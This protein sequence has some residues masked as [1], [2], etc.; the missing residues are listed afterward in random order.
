MAPKRKADA[1]GNA[2]KKQKMQ[3]GKKAEAPAPRAKKLL[4]KD[5]GDF[6]PINRWWEKDL[7]QPGA[8]AEMWKS[9]EHHGI[10]F[11]PPYE[12]HGKVLLY[13]GKPVKL[14]VEAE[15]IATYWA[16]CI[17]TDYVEKK[18]FQDN[19]WKSWKPT[20]PADT[21][22]TDFKKCDFRNIRKHLDETREARLGR[23]KEE[24]EAE[25]LKKQKQ[26]EYYRYAMVDGLRET[27]GNIMAEPPQL[28]RGRGEHP[29]MGLLKKRI[30][31]EMVTINCG[32]D[33]PVPK[34]P[35]PGHAWND[36]F[37]DNKSTWLGF[38]MDTINGMG[39]YVMLNAASGFKGQNDL[40]KYEKAR[41]LKKIAPIIRKDYEKL[42]DSKNIRERQVGVASYI[43]DRLALRAG[44]EKDT[45]E[46]ADTV[47]CCSLRVEHMRFEGDNKITLDFLGKD[48]I[49]YVNTVAVEPGV[50]RCLEG[51]SSGKKPD[52]MI[53]DQIDTGDVNEYFKRFMPELSAKVFRTYNASI[54][55]Q[56]ELAKFDDRDDIDP[57]NPNELL[58]FYNDANREVAILCNHQR[59]V[60]KSHDDTIAKMQGQLDDQ[61][62]L[63]AALEKHLKFFKGKNALAT[64]KGVEINGFK[65]P[66]SKDATTK[67]LG[68]VQ[69]RIVEQDRKIRMKDDNKTV[70]LGTS[71][72]NYMDPR[73]SVA[74]CKKRELQIEKI[75][76][77]S[78]RIKFPWAMH[79]PSTYEF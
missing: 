79:F 13:D 74:F 64:K 78:T 29:K 55:L 35:I 71:K 63:E 33:A 37:H 73:I 56:E 8:D 9:L 10:F 4:Q 7:E 23:S 32:E 43:I 1:G 75:F 30:V 12:P 66:T 14:D 16:S 69:N 48:S 28:F 6:E 68:E 26:E 57:Y 49:Q 21:V 42:W 52:E 2:K 65:M 72:V 15:E 44:N 62:K 40:R 59:A 58:Q 24:K 38:Y 54:T 25:K 60:P 77:K 19:F 39:K 22:I 34:C 11:P 51:F 45:E 3:K 70:S 20:L 5:E 31:P 61:K 76:P 46:E 27:V 50:Y 17:G 36:V 18:A 67:K 41:K 47:G 53:F